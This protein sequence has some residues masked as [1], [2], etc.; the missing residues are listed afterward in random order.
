M[1]KLLPAGMLPSG[2]EL[3]TPL[4]YYAAL[5]GDPGSNYATDLNVPPKDG[6]FVL[7]KQITTSASNVAPSAKVR[8]SMRSG[9]VNAA[10]SS[11]QARS[12]R[13]FVGAISG[14]SAP[15]SDR[16]R[17]GP[18]LGMCRGT[19]TSTQYTCG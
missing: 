12:L 19:Q 16:F 13:F 1:M 6:E 15:S 7:V 11:T 8:V 10:T 17:W 3:K 18:M 9:V 4:P 2:Q 5:P 14:R